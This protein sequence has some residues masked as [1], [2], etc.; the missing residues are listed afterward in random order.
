[1]KTIK[2]NYGIDQDS[3]IIGPFETSVELS[4]GDLKT[5]GDVIKQHPGEKVKFSQ[6][7]EK[8]LDKFAYAAVE[9]YCDDINETPGTYNDVIL[10]A[11]IPSGVLDNLCSK[12]VKLLPEGYYEEIKSKEHFDE[13][14]TVC[15]GMKVDSIESQ[16]DDSEWPE[17]SKE[18]TLYL[19]I[20]QVYF[21]EIM[22]GT[23]KE[24]Y[25]EITDTTYKKY[26]ACDKKGNVYYNSDLFDG[27]EPDNLGDIY[28]YNNGEYPYYPKDIYYLDLAVGYNKVRDTATVRVN[29]ISFIS[30]ADMRFRVEDGQAI[31]DMDGDYC[32]WIIVFHLGDI[33]KKDII[34]K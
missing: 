25:R 1:M 27:N 29:D 22:A 5:I 6:V 7:P 16:D 32:R 3:E 18:N 24:E 23:K 26:L 15:G 19:P 4:D 20:K 12:T 11:L 28:C 21:D 13:E 14:C 10:P 31:P 8:I 30:S 34:S 33:V 17:Q 2:F 9:D